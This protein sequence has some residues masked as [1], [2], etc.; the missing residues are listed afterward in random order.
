MET[1]PSLITYLEDTG[2]PHKITSTT[3]GGHSPT[4]YHYQGQAV[5]AAGPIPSVAS[6]ELIAIQ[7][8]WLL[9]A[10]ELAELIG[11][12]PDACLKNGHFIRYDP[13]TMDAHQNHVHTAAT[14]NVTHPDPAP[15]ER[16][17]AALIV[18]A[19]I[20]HPTWPGYLEVQEDGGVFAFD[21]PF[22]GSI[23]GLAGQNDLHGLDRIISAGPSPTGQGYWLMS[24]NG[25]VYAFGDAEYL[26]GR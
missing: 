15:P 3:G 16:K 24:A 6:P 14:V 17:K 26:G 22:Y 13:D 18:T 2:L 5:D 1:Y 9:I 8:S 7:R 21:A 4:S 11:P 19:L 10:E 25:N 12:D 20:T 23:P